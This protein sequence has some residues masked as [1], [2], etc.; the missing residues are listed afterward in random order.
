MD[1]T[2]RW[3]IIVGVVTRLGAGRS[4]VQI[5]VQASNFA[6]LHHIQTGSGLTE[7]LIRWVLGF[8]PGGKATGGEDYHSPP[9]SPEV[10]SKWSY[11][12]TPPI[13]LHGVDRE[14]FA[15]LYGPHKYFMWAKCRTFFC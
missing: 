6:L 10:K 13:S 14:N 3:S 15:V 5:P 8:F 9:S 7:P 12:S 11:T 4:G 2:H 1:H